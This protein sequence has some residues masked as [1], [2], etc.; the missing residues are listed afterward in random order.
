LL[1]S[2]KVLGAMC[3]GSGITFKYIYLWYIG[4][5]GIAD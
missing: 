3:K 4:E 2:A 5:Y 1:D